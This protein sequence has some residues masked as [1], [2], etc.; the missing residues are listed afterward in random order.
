MS[1]IRL[2]GVSKVYQGAVR[3]VDNVDLEIADGEFVV[4]VGPSGCGKTTLLRMIAGLETVTEG[5]VWIGEENVTRLEPSLRD[6]AMVFQNYALYPHMT[7][8]QN[9]G[10]GLKLRRVPKQE[11]AA[12]VNAVA[13]MLGLDGL[14]ERKPSELSGGQRQRVAIGRAMVREPEAYLM[15][16]PLSNL[17]AKLRVGMRAELSRLHARLGVTTVYVTHDQAEAMTLGDRVAVLRAG[18][19]QQCDDPQTLFGE[20]ANLFVAAFIGSPSMNLVEAQ[21]SDDGVIFAGHRQ[22]QRL[23]GDL[24]ARA[25]G[26]A[27]DQVHRRRADEA[28]DEGR[29]RPVIDLVGRADLLHAAGVQI[30]RAHV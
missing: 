16:E 9:L 1:A 13:A 5:S 17:D 25:I 29:C 18:I 27:F 6:I 12:R 3:A 11:I 24:E 20:P 22:R 15:D 2:E 8:R 28:G 14:L 7:A 21:V 26:T 30:G 10:F 23:P 19:L 4:L